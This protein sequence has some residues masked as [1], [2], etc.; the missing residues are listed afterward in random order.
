MIGCSQLIPAHFMNPRLEHPNFL[1]ILQSVKMK[2]K[3]STEFI[4][5]VQAPGSRG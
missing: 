1:Y 5:A 3:F 2:I 4:V